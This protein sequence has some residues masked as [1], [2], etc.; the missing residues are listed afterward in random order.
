MATPTLQTKWSRNTI[1]AVS[2]VAALHFGFSLLVWGQFIH[3]LAPQTRDV[4]YF[5]R[6]A[7]VHCGPVLLL[8]GLFLVAG[9]LALQRKRFASRWLGIAVLAT[10]ALGWYDFTYHGP[11]II[12]NNMDGKGCHHMYWT[13]WWYHD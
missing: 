2:V 5:V 7:L 4:G 11:Q 3:G 12:Y 13:W 10:I 8:F 9:V 1:L 6:Y